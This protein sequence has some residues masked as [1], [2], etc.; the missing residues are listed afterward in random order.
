RND[1]MLPPGTST[2]APDPTPMAAPM[3]VLRGIAVSPGIAV[4]PI[5]VLDRRGMRLPPRKITAEAV[6]RELERLDDGLEIAGREAG[7]SPAGPSVRRH[8]GGP[9]PHDRRCHAPRRHA[10]PGRA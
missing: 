3:H 2:S 8:P 9:R 10:R 1:G 5:L 6:E 7:S 4:G